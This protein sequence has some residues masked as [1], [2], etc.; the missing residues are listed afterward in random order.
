MDPPGG[1]WRAQAPRDGKKTRE[2]IRNLPQPGFKNGRLAVEAENY[3]DF[4]SGSCVS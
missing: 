1:G 4:V 3:Y 2:M